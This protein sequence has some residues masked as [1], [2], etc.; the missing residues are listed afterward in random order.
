MGYRRIAVS[1]ICLSGC[2]NIQDPVLPQTSSWQEATSL[3]FIR[4][5]LS[6]VSL[7]G[8]ILLPGGL[9]K[10]YGSRS[11]LRD[12][13]V[14]DPD[15]D[16]WS[17][18]RPLPEA[19]NNAGT[20]A[21]LGKLYV[22]GGFNSQGSRRSSL[23][24][25]DPALDEWDSGLDMPSRRGGLVAAAVDGKL[26]AIGGRIRREDTGLNEMYDP[27]VN[28]WSE[29][30]PMPTARTHHSCAVVDGKI[31]VF[32]GRQ[33]ETGV[34]VSTLEVYNPATDSWRKGADLPRPL[35]GAAVVAFTGRIYVF[36]GEVIG[37]E[38]RVI[39]EVWV[40][41]P[42]FEDYTPVAFMP[43]PRHDMAAVAHEGRIFLFGGG[44]DSG[45]TPSATNEFFIP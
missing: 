15:S 43:T 22:V 33:L 1:L 6:A 31:Y 25:F 17:P 40:Y 19:R 2:G 10:P 3:A 45:F 34:S 8:R 44:I 20:T 26:Y 7:N 18:G 28:V 23:F 32:G 41:H 16:V 9:G 11:T 27:A 38:S 29:R 36:G 21:L 14:Y 39:N 5:E 37:E 13:S 35:S 24:V 42:E 4:Q 30:S 12:L